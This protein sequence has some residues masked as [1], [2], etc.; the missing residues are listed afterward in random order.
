M[1]YGS[2]EL[3]NRLDVDKLKNL[4]F[5][6]GKEYIMDRFAKSYEV[7]SNRIGQDDISQVLWRETN[8]IFV[9]DWAKTHGFGTPEASLMKDASEK[10]KKLNNIF[11]AR[12]LIIPKPNSKKLK[13]SDSVKVSQKL[14]EMWKENNVNADVQEIPSNT[15]YIARAKA[16]YERLNHRGNKL[17][18]EFIKNYW[19]KRKT[20]AET[21]TV[22]K[23]RKTMYKSLLTALTVETKKK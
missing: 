6:R 16:L 22:Y 3:D 10:A 9:E 21:E 5:E 11:L 1:S 13:D 15:V 2:W 23:Q 19:K 7:L 18:K 20:A 4:S 12:F 14:I 17:G 8:N